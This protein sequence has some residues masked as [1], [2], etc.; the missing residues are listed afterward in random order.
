M[1]VITEHKCELRLS[2]NTKVCC[3]RQSRRPC[4]LNRGSPPLYFRSFV[5]C[6]SFFSIEGHQH[7][8]GNSSHRETTILML[9]RVYTQRADNVNACARL[10]E[11]TQGRVLLYRTRDGR[12]PRVSDA[13]VGHTRRC[14]RTPIK[15]DEN[16]NGAG[17]AECDVTNRTKQSTTKR[18]MVSSI[19]HVVDALDGVIYHK[20]IETARRTQ[21]RLTLIPKRANR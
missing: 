1:C 14:F 15:G 17:Q 8:V 20:R 9:P 18:R 13:A 21:R 7:H 4:T 2:F 10:L 16:G 12:T 11:V 19:V 3:N 5:V 6:I